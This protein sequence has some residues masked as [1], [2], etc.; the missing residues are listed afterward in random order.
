MRTMRWWVN[1]FNFVNGEKADDFLSWVDP[2]QPFAICCS[3]FLFIESLICRSQPVIGWLSTHFTHT[4]DETTPQNICRR[5][6]SFVPFI[7]LV[8]TLFYGAKEKFLFSISFF[9]AYV[10]HTSGRSEKNYT[11]KQSGGGEDKLS[12]LK[13]DGQIDKEK[14]A[15]IVHTQ[16]IAN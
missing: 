1:K 16:I 13:T 2:S 11:T 6:S 10:L 9:F 12:G 4:M 7:F 14:H 8:P 3:L 5:N 15:H